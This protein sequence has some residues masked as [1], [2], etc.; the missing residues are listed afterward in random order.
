MPWFEALDQPGAGQMKHGRR[1]MES[2]PFL[3]RIPDNELIVPA[4][5]ETA[6]PGAGRYRFVATRDAEGTYAM[7]YVPVGRSLSVRTRLLK[8]ESLRAWW[9]DPRTGDARLIGEFP[10][11]GERTFVPP[12]PGENLDWILVL[13]DAA[14]NYPAPG[15]VNRQ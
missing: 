3:S 6:V 5:V 13:D 9:Y 8:R 12:T 2:R 15:A 4:K 10:N 1:L 7:I 14:R 11:S